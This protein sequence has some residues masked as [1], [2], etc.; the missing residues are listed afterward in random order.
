MTKKYSSCTDLI[1]STSPNLIR[2]TG[3]ELSTFETCH[4]NLIYGIIDPSSAMLF[5]RALGLQKC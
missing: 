2:A 1:F 3:I 4:L 5:D